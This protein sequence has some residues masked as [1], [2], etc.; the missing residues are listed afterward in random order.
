MEGFAARVLSA[1]VTAYDSSPMHQSIT[2]AGGMREGVR[3]GLAVCAA[4]AIVGKISEV[5]L[6][7]SRV[8]LLTDA[9]SSLP[10]RVQRTRDLCVLQGT[11]GGTCSVDWLDRYAGVQRG[12]VLVSAPVDELISRKPLI[13]AGLP[14]AT[15]TLAEPGR[16]EPMFKH[17]TASPLVNVRRLE[18]VEVVVPAQGQAD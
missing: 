3:E 11:G 18:V 12:D 4:G 17:V 15:V 9:A 14:V 7:R 16:A 10:C 13:P 5:G 1:P 6:W 2:I 8:R